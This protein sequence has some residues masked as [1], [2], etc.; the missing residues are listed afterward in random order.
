MKIINGNVLDGADNT[1]KRINITIENGK[2]IAMDKSVEGDNFNAEGCYVIPGFID[3]HIHGCVG[4]EFASPSEDFSP[5][6]K[7]LA[8][9]GTTGF[10]ATIRSLPLKRIIAAEH[11][12]IK[13]AQKEPCGAKV[14][15]INLEGP[16]ISFSKSGVMNPPQIEC[17][18][19]SVR[20]LSDE[21]NGLLKLMTIAPERENSYEAI[22]EAVACGVNASMGHTESDYETAKGAIDAGA[23]RGTHVF[24]AMRPFSHRETG[25]LGAVLTDDRVNC[26]MICDL[27]HLD[28]AAIKLVYRAKG[29]KNI[30]L[31]SDTGFMSGLPDGEYLVDGRTR[32]VENGVCRNKEGRIAGSCVS[33]LAGARNLLTLGIPMEEISVMAS[34][35]PAKAIGVDRDTGS[36]EIGKYADLII[37]DNKFNIK[38]VFVNGKKV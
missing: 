32:I 18:R 10:A 5:A 7:W 17:N 29:Y 34:L 22:K 12:I 24:N 3:T 8:S 25:V 38:A 31:I 23:C 27:V 19:E 36:I 13:E 37:C 11:N 33:M 21:S 16:F 1:F 2:I 14:L 30:T 15:A 20:L 4:V 35:N 28:E 6:Q 26:E 9:Q